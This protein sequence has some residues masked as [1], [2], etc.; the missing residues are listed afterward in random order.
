MID[1]Y[2]IFYC[3]IVGKFQMDFSKVSKEL[4]V[5]KKFQFLNDPQLWKSLPSSIVNN[6][7]FTGPFIGLFISGLLVFHVYHLLIWFLEDKYFSEK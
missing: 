1:K 4:F 5:K 3:T 6:Y 7:E 2:V